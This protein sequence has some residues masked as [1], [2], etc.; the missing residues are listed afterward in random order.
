MCAL[1]TILANK[2]NPQEKQ[3]STTSTPKNFKENK[4]NSNNKQ[5]HSQ[6]GLVR[7]TE[8]K[9]HNENDNISILSGQRLV[10]ECL[11]VLSQQIKVNLLVNGLQLSESHRFQCLVL[12]FPNNC[13]KYL[14]VY[15]RD[16][17]RF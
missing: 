3:N 8:S 5:S 4:V 12:L 1:K 2:H 7:C 13:E 16:N 10:L 9:V 15:K 14:T 17:S 11:L 6:K